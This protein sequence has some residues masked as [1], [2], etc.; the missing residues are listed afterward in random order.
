M[1]WTIIILLIFVIGVIINSS[2][3]KK[4]HTNPN[5]LPD[6]SESKI[7]M[8]NRFRN[9]YLEG[10]INFQIPSSVID[11]WAEYFEKMD[12]KNNNVD[13]RQWL[14]SDSPLPDHVMIF[15]I[16]RHVHIFNALYSLGYLKKLVIKRHQL[17]T[18]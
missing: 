13:G 1:S 2:N 14:Y 11:Y 10:K 5:N 4:N 3:A 15:A 9:D 12:S 18:P 7:L 8:V 16:I 6:T 17:V